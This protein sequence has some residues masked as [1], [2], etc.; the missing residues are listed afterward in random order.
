MSNCPKVLLWR[1]RWKW[2]NSA[3]D[4]GVLRRSS[5]Y[6][7]RDRFFFICYT[8]VPWDISGRSPWR[9]CITSLRQHVNVNVTDDEE[10]RLSKAKSKF[11]TCRS[12][13]KMGTNLFTGISSGKLWGSI[14][15]KCLRWRNILTFQLTYILSAFICV[16]C[17]PRDCTLL[18]S[19]FLRN[20]CMMTL[21]TQEI[22]L[23]LKMEHYYK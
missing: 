11:R 12:T 22:Q 8:R 1:K 23:K 17:L 18:W 10:M 3:V 6:Q 16:F 13:K 20:L 21:F 19:K 2:Q 9:K 15:R 5:F 7:C 4:Y 14:V